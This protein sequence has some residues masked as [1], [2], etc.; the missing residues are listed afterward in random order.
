MNNRLNTK[1][2]LAKDKLLEDIGNMQLTDD[3]DMI[4]STF[5]NMIKQSTIK[6]TNNRFEPKEWWTKELTKLFAEKRQQLLAYNRNPTIQ[7][8]LLLKN[9]NATFIKQAKKAKKKYWE[10]FREELSEMKTTLNLIREILM[11]SKTATKK[12]TIEFGMMIKTKDI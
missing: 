3:A 5:Q 11:D 6:I 12:N 7:N 9:K 2:F 4:Q 8:L 10:K 1:F